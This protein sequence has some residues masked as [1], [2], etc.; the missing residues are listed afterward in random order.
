LL[1]AVLD[2]LPSL[3]ATK[4]QPRLSAAFVALVDLFSHRPAVRLLAPHLPTLTDFLLSFIVD[5][6]WEETVRFL[7]IEMLVTIAEQGGKPIFEDAQ[8]EGW[9]KVTRT[10]L[11]LMSTVQEDPNWQFEEALTSAEEEE[12][13]SSVAEQALDRL[14]LVGMYFYLALFIS[15]GMSAHTCV[16]VCEGEKDVLPAA[17]AAIPALIQS[18]SWQERHAGLSALGTLAEACNEGMTR[19]LGTMVQYAEILLFF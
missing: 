5:S 15:N 4:S 12:Q 19:E 18:Q 10:L 9:A 6:S 11:G 2:V 13:A 17:F 7:A 16:C 1:L 8:R 3:A 14:A